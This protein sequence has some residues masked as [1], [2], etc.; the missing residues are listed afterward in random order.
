VGRVAEIG[1]TTHELRS[2]DVALQRAFGFLGK[3][4]NGM[5]LGV[6][7]GGAATFGELRRAVTG[8]SDSVLSDRLSE[9]VAVGLIA[10]IVDDGPPIGVTY[11]LT[12]AGAQLGP[13]M[14]ALVD[15]A[16]KNLPDD[17]DT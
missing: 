6:L 3:R 14:A 13:V 11:E 2:C 7:T 4:W 5:I 9:L 8:I 17:A 12:D 16:N 15:W 10:R 1:S